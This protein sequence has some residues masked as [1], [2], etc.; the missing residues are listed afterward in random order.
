[1]RFDDTSR[2]T[3][4][5]LP[6]VGFLLAGALAVMV[7]A[8]APAIRS[9]WYDAAPQLRS[10]NTVVFSTTKNASVCFPGMQEANLCWGV[11]DLAV[12]LV[13]WLI[14]FGAGIFLVMAALGSDPVEKDAKRAMQ[15]AE[16]KKKEARKKKGRWH[17]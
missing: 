7:L 10:A 15:I 8:L 9:V 4:W 3:K 14:L 1:M 2:K 6:A 16:K 17:G 12:A 13:A 5:W 11:V